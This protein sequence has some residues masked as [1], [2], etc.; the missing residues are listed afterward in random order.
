VRHAGGPFTG[1]P[2]STGASHQR[3]AAVTGLTLPVA[4]GLL[5]G[6]SGSTLRLRSARVE[7]SAFHCLSSGRGAAGAL[8][9][10]LRMTRRTFCWARGYRRATSS[11]IS[12]GCISAPLDRRLQVPVLS[13]V[14]RLAW[15]ED[16]HRHADR[17]QHPA[18]PVRAHAL[19]PG[20]ILER[21]GRLH[22]RLYA[23][24]SAASCSCS[25]K[26]GRHDRRLSADAS[27]ASFN[28]AAVN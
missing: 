9:V 12:A 4:K 16:D 27:A 2:S 25:R 15:G 19:D 18:G 14:P 23:A 10:G 20:R 13:V 8:Q 3:V 7:I 1:R 6:P 21:H 22:E 17:R 24:S 5:D 28:L 26:G 11:S